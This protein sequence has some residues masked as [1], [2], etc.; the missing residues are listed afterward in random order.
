MTY[1]P[2]GGAVAALG[3][4][5]NVS[6]MGA[7]DGQTINYNTT[8][9]TW[10]PSTPA[11]TLPGLSDVVFPSPPST[12]DVLQFGGA[13]WGAAAV[14]GG[15]N[16]VLQ[17]KKVVSVAATQD[18][19]FTG[20]DGNAVIAYVFFVQIVE[21]IASSV[22]YFW[23]PNGIPNA[24]GNQSS[25]RIAAFGGSITGASATIM[26]MAGIPATTGNGACIWM[27]VHPNAASVRA[28][29]CFS[30]EKRATNSPQWRNYGGMW[31][32]TSANLTSIKLNS[33]NAAGYNIG[34]I[35]ACYKVTA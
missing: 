22:N 8:G 35:A 16:F 24:G 17:E 14:A 10:Y 1:S 12:N 27:V 20:L 21:T 11:T 7:V 33:N 5:G 2:G 6:T 31:D 25:E 13:T 32:D 4:I 18:L 28:Y 15:G 23:E 34:T 29:H 30:I 19:D 3:D 9:S 26:Y